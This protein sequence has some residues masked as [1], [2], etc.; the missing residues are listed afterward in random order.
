MTRSSFLTRARPYGLAILFGALGAL[1]FGLGALAGWIWIGHEPPHFGVEVGRA[2]LTL[3]S[4]LILG[5]AVK[6][7]LD[8]YQQSQEKCEQARQS[9]RQLVEELRNVRQRTASA[10]LMIKAHKSTE[11]YAE[12]MSVLIDCRVALLKLKHTME[13]LRGR[14]SRA[15]PREACLDGMADYLAA[16]S[17]EYAD[18]Y[19]DLN[20]RE[21]Y[22]RAVVQHHISEL[23]AT[24]T[25]FDADEVPINQ[26]WQLMR[27]TCPRLKDLIDGGED[28]TKKFRLPLHYLIRHLWSVRQVNQPNSL[29][30]EGFVR[31][32]ASTLKDALNA[33]DDPTAEDQA[34]DVTASP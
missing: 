24:N 14:T 21:R 16:L 7:T 32:F 2:A 31:G 34:G 22:D 23:A 9:R 3:G 18:H 4:G 19:C 28:Y 15:D 11:A 33:V 30:D 25:D 8:H 6:V 12:Q 26:A 10:R 29:F 13:L 17:D 1:V 20:D 5:G 27:D